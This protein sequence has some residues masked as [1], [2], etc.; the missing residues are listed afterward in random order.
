M[1]IKL[2]LDQTLIY[3]YVDKPERENVEDIGREYYPGY[4][5][6]LRP[7]VH[8]FLYSLIDEGHDLEIVTFADI[9]Y[10]KAVVE[11]AG[12]P[13]SEITSMR[14]TFTSS[15]SLNIKHRNWLLLD[16]VLSD[17]KFHYISGERE[18]LNHNAIRAE[19]FY[20]DL[21]DDYLKKVA[22]KTILKLSE[23]PI[24]PCTLYDDA[25]ERYYK[26]MQKRLS[27]LT[28]E[29][30]RFIDIVD[31]CDIWPACFDIYY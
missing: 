22:L 6:I 16:D 26:L 24:F 15:S 30:K 21:K 14:D 19:A 23:F 20:G 13:V 3:S 11:G 29:D 10:A 12:F 9:D 31:R 17:V 25:E 27:S 4:K 28:K 2:D 7:N 1:I 5:T 8:H 18:M